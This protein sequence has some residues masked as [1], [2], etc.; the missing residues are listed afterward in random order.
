[1]ARRTTLVTLI[2]GLFALVPVL[3]FGQSAGSSDPPKR[4]GWQFEV[5]GGPLSVGSLSKVVTSGLPPPG[6]TFPDFRGG[7]SRVV[8][9]WFFGDGALLANQV[10]AQ[11][12][13]GVSIVPLDPALTQAAANRQGGGHF[14]VRIGHTITSHVLAEFSF[15]SISGQ[16]AI[17]PSALAN[18]NATAQSFQ[19]Y[20]TAV[21]ARAATPNPQ[22]S[23]TPTIVN[24][25]NNTAKIMLGEA[26]INLVSIRGWTPYIEFGGGILFPSSD[27]A[28]VALVGQYQATLSNMG[29]NNGT[30]FRQADQV[31]VRFQDEP[32]VVGALGGGV[33]RQLLSHLGVRIDVRA[34]LGANDLRTRLVT[35]PTSSPMP[36]G[37][38]GV[39]ARGVAPSLQISANQNQSSLASGI[40]VFDTFEGKGRLV[41]VSIGAFVR[42]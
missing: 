31:R 29:A 33:E 21:I 34:L 41:L 8:P 11:T 5:H 1:M 25:V 17:S 13:D 23:A 35:Q 7:Q 24:N 30:V 2:A 16:I 39:I 22:V 6:S 37:P 18:I 36:V 12:G 38:G 4:I 27:E 15:D 9:S 26:A 20:F 10:S 14:G 19:S 42:F 28:S 40:G 32:A 3:A